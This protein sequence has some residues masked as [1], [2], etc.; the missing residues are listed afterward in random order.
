MGAR[1]PPDLTPTGVW[2]ATTKRDRTR[3]RR[4]LTARLGDDWAGVVAE[5]DRRRREQRRTTRTAPSTVR[6]QAL[7]RLELIHTRPERCNPWT[8]QPSVPG[9]LHG[10]TARFR[11]TVSLTDE[12]TAEMVLPCGVTDPALAL[13]VI[14]H[15]VPGDKLRVTGH[16]RLPRTPDEPVWLAVTTLAGLETAPVLT[17]PAT[18]ATH[19]LSPTR[20][21]SNSGR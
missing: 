4:Q 15:L 2:A 14:H 19:G 13:A 10:S 6:D 20:I 11:L 1:Q 17:N 16:L 9:D 5:Q 18:N 8:P 7:T 21:P 12:R 3:L